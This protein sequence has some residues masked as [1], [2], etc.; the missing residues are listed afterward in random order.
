MFWQW[1][2]QLPIRRLA[3]GVNMGDKYGD[4]LESNY[5]NRLIVGVL[6]DS[7]GIVLFEPDL[8]EGMEIQF[9]TRDSTNRIVESVKNNSLQPMK[10]II[11]D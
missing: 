3:I 9:M 8:R 4:F 6:P 7:S 10:Q 2:Q 1:R 11:N 5:I